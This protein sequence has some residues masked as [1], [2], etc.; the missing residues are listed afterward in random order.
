MSTAN[1]KQIGG[2]HYSKNGEQH[3]DMMWRLYREAWFV[4]NITKYVLRYRKKNGM[5]DLEKAK[6]YLEKLIELEVANE[7][8]AEYDSMSSY[9]CQD[10]DLKGGTLPPDGGVEQIPQEKPRAPNT[11]HK[12]EAVLLNDGSCSNRCCPEY[13]EQSR[14]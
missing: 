6:H 5:Q 4:G 7:Q 8:D 2:A 9:V 14:G 13:K 12:C 11:C 1:E 10:P 3:W